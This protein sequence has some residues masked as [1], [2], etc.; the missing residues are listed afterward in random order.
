MLNA[1]LTNTL[2]R[3]VWISLLFLLA[4]L[5]IS[6]VEFKEA[7]LVKEVHIKVQPLPNGNTLVNKADIAL[8][9]EKSFG[10]KF[11]GLSIGA[12]EVERLE[13]VLEEDPFIL[14]ADVYIDAQNEINII[15]SQRQPVLRIID[16]NGLNYYL[17]KDGFK[18]PL[19]KHYSARVLVATGN[20]PPHVPDFL[21]RKKHVLKDLF[22]LAEM[23]GQD[24]FYHAMFEQL[25]VSNRGEFTLIPM[26][27]NQKVIFGKLDNAQDKLAR[28]K[29]FYKEGMP[30]RGWHRYKTINLKYD[31]QV[32]CKKR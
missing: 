15:V 1:D 11:Q 27:G 2:K 17:D 22:L 24:D 25:F 19:S 31:N 20:I 29:L 26:V 4:A 3:L 30:Y 16:N 28:L 5:V 23:I 8:T 9:I 6:G 10:F 13:R 7:S 18:L 32:V 14:N 21:E 12:I